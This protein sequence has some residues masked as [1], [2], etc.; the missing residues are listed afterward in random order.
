VVVPEEP[1]PCRGLAAYAGEGAYALCSFRQAGDLPGTNA[2]SV[3]RVSSIR[4][5]S[6]MRCDVAPCACV[7]CV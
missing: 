5:D 4:F 7:P 3:D 2:L 1:A 6:C